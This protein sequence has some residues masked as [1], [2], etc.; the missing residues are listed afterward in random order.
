MA[1]LTLV[2]LNIL[3]TDAGI[4]SFM[5]DAGVIPAVPMKDMTETA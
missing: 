2:C 3:H 5:K 4:T 1:I